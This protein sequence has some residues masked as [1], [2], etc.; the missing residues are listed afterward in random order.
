M[1]SGLPPGAGAG[2]A[3]P[4]RPRGVSISGE[5]RAGPGPPPPEASPPARRSRARGEGRPACRTSP[6]G[7]RRLFH[8]AV[9][10][11]R[12][13]EG[14]GQTRQKNKFPPARSGRCPAEPGA[15]AGQRR[16]GPSAALPPSVPPAAGGEGQRPGRERL[17][18]FAARPPGP[19][20]LP[21]PRPPGRARRAQGAPAPPPAPWAAH[22]GGH[23]AAGAGCA[24]ALPSLPLSVPRLL[25][26]SVCRSVCPARPP[27][28]GRAGGSSSASPAA[29]AA[30]WGPPCGSA[31]NA[32]SAGPAR[33]GC[34]GRPAITRLGPLSAGPAPHRGTAFARSLPAWP[35]AGRGSRWVRRSRRSRPAGPGRWGRMDRQTDPAHPPCPH[36]LCSLVR[37]WP[38]ILARVGQR[39]R[40]K[41]LCAPR[42]P[43]NGNFKATI[44]QEKQ[45]FPRLGSI[46]GLPDLPR[47]GLGQQRFRAAVKA[48]RTRSRP[49]VF[50]LGTL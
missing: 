18:R 41:A 25:A 3:V 13:G 39:A 29:A 10:L 34:S 24:A 23:G 15:G 33:G 2:P 17:P 46:R 5:N 38:R 44:R 16:R 36:G 43:L 49:V 6:S 1:D 19:P 45:F 4:G 28:L 14:G 20:E 35:G 8:P 50:L 9:V 37:A 11:P 31:A 21:D 26:L 30:S 42:G 48:P 7:L 22:L 32:P 40:R 47:P 12:S 27:P